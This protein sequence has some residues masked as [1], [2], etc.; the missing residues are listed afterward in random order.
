MQ[1]AQVWDLTSSAPSPPAKQPA[2]HCPAQPPL[3]TKGQL[4]GVARRTPPLQQGLRARARLQV[5]NGH[6]VPLVP[7]ESA[8]GAY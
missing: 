4:Q 8:A 6:Q 5:R 1:K 3:P 2:G 7:E